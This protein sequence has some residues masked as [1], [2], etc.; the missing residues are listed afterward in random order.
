VLCN[1]Q[2]SHSEATWHTD[3][4]RC[5]LSITANNIHV[6]PSVGGLCEIV[7]ELFDTSTYFSFHRDFLQ[8]KI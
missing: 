1:S 2:C 4:R 8:G 7:Y 3:W 6:V 5:Q